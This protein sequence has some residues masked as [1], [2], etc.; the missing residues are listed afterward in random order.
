MKSQLEFLEIKAHQ[1]TYVQCA[2]GFGFG[3]H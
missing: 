2:I 3:S 1:K